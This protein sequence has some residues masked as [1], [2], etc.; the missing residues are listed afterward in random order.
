MPQTVSDVRISHYHLLRLISARSEDR[1]TLRHW[2]QSPRQYR[3]TIPPQIEI[4]VVY[5]K[6]CQFYPVTVKVK[7]QRRDR[8]HRHVFEKRHD[9][10][11]QIRE[12]VAE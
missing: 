1:Q 4:G 12:K 6:L 2:H 7:H 3:L 8:K 10:A 11:K 9:R 5:A